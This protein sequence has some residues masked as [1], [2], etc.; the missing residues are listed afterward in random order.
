[1]IQREKN[2][3]NDE[4]HQEDKR[5]VDRRCDDD[6]PTRHVNFRHQ[7]RFGKKRAHSGRRPFR[8]KIP[9]HKTGQQLQRIIMDPRAFRIEQG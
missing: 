8:K 9:D 2:D 3:D 6:R 5:R 7:L 1:M 4:V